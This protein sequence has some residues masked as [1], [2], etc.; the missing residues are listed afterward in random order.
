MLLVRLEM[1][2][3]CDVVYII[4]I[5]NLGN[6]SWKGSLYMLVGRKMGVWLIGIVGVIFFSLF[7][8]CILRAFF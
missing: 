4:G 2:M 6:L 1:L 3:V 7:D 8:K 5:P